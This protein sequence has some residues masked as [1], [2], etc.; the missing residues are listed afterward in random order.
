[1]D[2]DDSPPEAIATAIAEETNRAIS[3]R[4]VETNGAVNAAR[5]IA[6]LL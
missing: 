1:M 2:I 3:Y 5:R 4:D 6:D